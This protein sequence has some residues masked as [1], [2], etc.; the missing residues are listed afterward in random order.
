FYHR[1]ASAERGLPPHG[2]NTVTDRL[3]WAMRWRVR[4]GYPLSVVFFWLARPTQQSIIFGACIA[5]LGLIVRAAAAGTLRKQ[6]ELA[7]SG[8]Y[9]HTRNPLYLGSALMALGMLVAGASWAAAVLVTLYFA[10]FYTAVMRREERELAARFG[11]EFRTYAANVPL[12]LP[13]LLAWQG[14]ATPNVFSWPQY[15]RNREWRSAIGMLLV[16]A[17]L[18][19][20]M[21]W[22]PS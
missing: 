11:E 20:R 4:L 6:E 12:F 5:I 18:W 13:R 22:F 21:I 10:I 3:A 15:A 14:P 1:G 2:C 8:I 7:T 16:L 17:L 9:A 19:A